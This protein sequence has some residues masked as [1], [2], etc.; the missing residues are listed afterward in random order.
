M[1]VRYITDI[2]KVK[3]LGVILPLSEIKQISYSKTEL[4]EFFFSTLIFAVFFS[5]FSFSFFFWVLMLRLFSHD[6]CP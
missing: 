2:K 1:Y 3:L 5:F 4:T 6:Y